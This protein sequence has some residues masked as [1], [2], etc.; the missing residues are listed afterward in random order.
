MVV[1]VQLVTYKT[2]ETV[3]MPQWVE[4]QRHT[5]VVVC[6]CVS[7]CISYVYFSATTKT[8]H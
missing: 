1:F 8:K 6:V 2:F 5:V 7:V 3:V 4:L